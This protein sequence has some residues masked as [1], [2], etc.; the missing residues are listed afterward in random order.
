MRRAPSL[1]QLWP[2][3]AVALPVLASLLASMSAVDLAYQ[4]RAGGGIL[5]S[6]AIPAF[7]SWTSSAPVYAPW[8]W[9]DQQWG[10]QVLL[11]LVY[12]AA[13]WT[14]LAILR[15]ALVGLTCWLLLLLVRRRSPR[16]GPMGATLLVLAAFTVMAS[17]VALRPQLLAIP[18]FG[19][20]LLLIA[21]R[22][23]HPR[24]LWAI[25]LIT[26]LWANLQG[27]FPL[28]LVL[29]GLALVSDLLDRR[30]PR[31]LGAVTLAS[32]AATLVNPF[33]FDVWR[34]VVNVATNPAISSRVSEGRPP[35]PTDPPGI[36]FYLSALAVVA[37]LVVRARRAPAG[38]R[39]LPGWPAILTL[40]AF[41]ALAAVTGRGLAWWPPAALFVVA[42]LSAEVVPVL[43]LTSSARPSRLNTWVMA[44]F[45]VVAV[46][47]LPAWRP[48]GPAGV[49][50]GTLSNAPQGIA[51]ALRQGMDRST[52]SGVCGG[53]S[54]NRMWVPQVWASWFEFAAPTWK[55]EVDSRIEIFAGY[56]WIDYDTVRGG[57]PINSLLFPCRHAY[58]WIVTMPTDTALLYALVT[59]RQWIPVYHD[60]EG[61]IWARQ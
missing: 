37:L 5:D 23:T 27:A 4:L 39:R 45:A 2:F 12:R 42:P 58:T 8:P 14:G 48:L 20:S 28:V 36:L 32:A 30:T 16:L 9:L 24:R 3:L 43:R 53:P 1:A 59:S 11:A 46:G 60:A 22:E 57:D 51:A 25:P 21:D 7:D 41:G 15:A 13:G 49:P 47:L 52:I 31:L 10:A 54:S 55:Y 56:V 29:L 44:L 18:L 40:L 34:Y 61:T 33:G 17:S 26:L 50:V 38:A 35:T 19:L 6:R